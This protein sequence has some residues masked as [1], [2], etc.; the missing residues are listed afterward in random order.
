MGLRTSPSTPPFVDPKWDC[1]P[2]RAKQ[3]LLALENV[4]DCLLFLLEGDEEGGGRG[5]WFASFAVISI[6]IVSMFDSRALGFE[7]RAEQVS[8]LADRRSPW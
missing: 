2:P 8:S 6:V 7:R 3:A 1:E 5:D 4:N